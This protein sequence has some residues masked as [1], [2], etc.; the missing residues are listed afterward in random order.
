MYGEWHGGSGGS[1]HTCEF[2]PGDEIFLVQVNTL[3]IIAKYCNKTLNNM[4]ACVYL[5][6]V[7]VNCSTL[8]NFNLKHQ[9]DKPM[10]LT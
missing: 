9:I 3:K 5:L 8:F 6:K 1:P 4:Q 2:N 10:K 7:S